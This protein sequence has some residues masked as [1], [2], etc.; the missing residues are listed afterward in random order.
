[1]PVS[2]AAMTTPPF[3]RSTKLVNKLQLSQVRR[4]TKKIR[5]LR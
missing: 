2:L 1:M 5:P 3:T 4:R